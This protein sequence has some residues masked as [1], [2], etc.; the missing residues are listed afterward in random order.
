MASIFGISG[1]VAILKIFYMNLE[2]SII[3]GYIFSY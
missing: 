2:Q 1:S 3:V